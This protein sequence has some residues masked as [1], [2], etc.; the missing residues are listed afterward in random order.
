MKPKIILPILDSRQFD[1]NL[2][3][4]AGSLDLYLCAMLQNYYYK[5][6]SK[7]DL[8]P[9]KTTLVL[10]TFKCETSVVQKL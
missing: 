3:L 2:C 6:T 5:I 9:R 4:V 1:L 7:V 8:A 10:M